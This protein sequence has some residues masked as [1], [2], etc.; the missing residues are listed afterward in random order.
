MK[1][2]LFLVIQPWACSILLKKGRRGAGVSQPYYNLVVRKRALFTQHPAQDFIR[3]ASSQDAEE[4]ESGRLERKPNNPPC[5]LAVPLWA[6]AGRGAV[7]PAASELLAPFLQP[8]SQGSAPPQHRA[9]TDTKPERLYNNTLYQQY[10]YLIFMPFHKFHFFKDEKKN[11]RNEC[12][13]STLKRT[14]TSF[15]TAEISPFQKA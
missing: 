11:K 15:L 12:F 6:G 7:L 14:K 2:W 5:Q 10:I 8:Q 4:G 9:Q 13:T 3:S 1:Y